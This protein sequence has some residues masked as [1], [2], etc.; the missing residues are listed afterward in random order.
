MDKIS[1]FKVTVLQM[2]CSKAS[3]TARVHRLY[4]VY[5]LLDL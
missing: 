1:C 4:L 5:M 3:A 2:V